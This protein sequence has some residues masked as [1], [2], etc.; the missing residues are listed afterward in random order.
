MNIGI[1]PNSAIIDL[2]ILNY[3]YLAYPNSVVDL[4]FSTSIYPTTT[5]RK[6][7]SAD[8]QYE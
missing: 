7:K 4:G 2:V 1:L 3:S 5:K 8:T 6:N